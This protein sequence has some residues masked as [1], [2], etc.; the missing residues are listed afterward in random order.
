[1]NAVMLWF[2]WLTK[3]LG[4]RSGLW[5]LLVIN[6]LG[7]IYGYYWYKNQ[8][9]ATEWY[10]LPFVPD[11]PTASLFFCFVLVAFLMGRQWRFVE[12]F[13]AVTLFKYGVW[14][15]VMI[16]WTGLLGGE[17]TW[18]H[19]MLIFSHIGMA[20]QA[21]LY[22]PY[23][24]FKLHHL[25][26]VATWTLTNDVLDYTLGIFPW[27]NYRLHPFLPQIYTFTV[28]LSLVGLLIFYLSV[29]CRGKRVARHVP[30]RH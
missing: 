10:L 6:T 14:A 26:L 13:A 23:F 29:V 27:L 17:L 15:T 24:S 25:L 8:L 1:M 9:A 28:C 4:Q 12:A 11:S 2:K 21:L 18:Q 20:V 19:Y 7:T 16:V 30:K 5:T 3:W 22:I